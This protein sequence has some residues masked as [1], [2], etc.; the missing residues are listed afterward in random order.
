MLGISRSTVER[1]VD[2]I[3]AI[4]NLKDRIFYIKDKL[5]WILTTE[6]R[7]LPI[8]MEDSLESFNIENI[9]TD[10]WIDES[11]LDGPIFEIK[12]WNDNFLWIAFNWN[13]YLINPINKS[14]YFVYNKS[15]K[16]S[17]DSFNNNIFH[18][19]DFTV[20]Y[21]R[22]SDQSNIFIID[23]S[24][25][26]NWKIIDTKCNWIFLDAFI[27][28]WNIIYVLTHFWIVK[29][30]DKNWVETIDSNIKINYWEKWFT[31][32][33][34]IFGDAEYIML[35]TDDKTI[36]VDMDNRVIT[37]F[38]YDND[39]KKCE[40]IEWW[41]EIY[42]RWKRSSW[43]MRKCFEWLMRWGEEELIM[44][45]ILTK[46]W[47]VRDNSRLWVVKSI[48]YFW[49]ECF[50][51]R[52][53]FNNQ[54]NILDPINRNLKFSIWYDHI[55]FCDKVIVKEGTHKLNSLLHVSTWDI[56][57]I[58]DSEGDLESIFYNGIKKISLISYYNINWIELYVIWKVDKNW[59]IS[60][61]YEVWKK[62]GPKRLKRDDWDN[63]DYYNNYRK[64]ISFWDKN[65]NSIKNV[66]S[67]YK[68]WV[69][70]T[71][72]INTPN[73]K[74]WIHDWN[75]TVFEDDEVLID[76]IN[77]WNYSNVSFSND[78]DWSD[79]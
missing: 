5:S 11:L 24:D 13:D 8:E 55:G 7:I 37:N 67:L 17:E 71:L 42:K 79:E 46:D 61:P 22:F 74:I 62:I 23:D 12:Y 43:Y 30:I 72:I 10:N 14:Y 4:S 59:D 32:K 34:Y 52:S 57:R 48:N 39:R 1:V 75:I 50:L 70:Y 29:L 53:K 58:Y 49:S 69:F 56:I 18:D 2:W 60:W 76:I 3:S 41:I 66:I 33:N 31:Y 68:N 78:K 35:K 19:Y 54:Y 21:L 15:I 20:S 16:S 73:K 40:I 64:I 36:F 45:E 26:M 25:I 65:W 28:N 77:W 51:V 38:W 6:N 63:F 47:K 44:N 9:F 27:R